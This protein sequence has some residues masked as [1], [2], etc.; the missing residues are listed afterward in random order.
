MV[1]IQEFW[2][3]QSF[4]QPGDANTL[5]YDLA[6]ILIEQ[7]AHDWPAFTRF[8]QD[9]S[10]TTPAPPR[11][12]SPGLDLG[13]LVTTLLERDTPKSWS[14][15][16][17]TGEAMNLFDLKG[18][19]ALVTGG[20]GG[21]GLGMAQGLAQA[22]SWRSPAA[23]R[24]RTRKPRRLAIALE[25]DPEGREGVPRHGRRSREAPR[26]LDIL[27]NNAGMN[28]RKQPQEF[29]LEEW[30]L[31]MDTNLTSAFVARRPPTRT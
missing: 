2:S 7:L 5:S 19:T 26:P 13:Q 11:R 18:K 8:V 17:A 25:A 20:N 22:R 16:P 24:R 3:G 27:V 4:Q 21:I 29:T 23:T 28:V 14:P 6:R 12:T 9:A 1:S 10:M 30:P 31:V 15:N